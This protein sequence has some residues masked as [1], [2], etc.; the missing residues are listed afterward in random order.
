MPKILLNL[1]YFS[2]YAQNFNSYS[3]PDSQLF[4]RS[5]NL[6]RV[7]MT[8]NFFFLLQKSIHQAVKV[9]SL[10]LFQIF[11]VQPCCEIQHFQIGSIFPYTLVKYLFDERFPTNIS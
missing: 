11:P 3:N 5:E 8:K 10:A 6:I 9:V 7:Q 2:S 4:D 1:S